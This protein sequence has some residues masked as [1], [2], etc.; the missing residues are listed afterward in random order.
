MG[1][2]VP[3]WKGDPEPFV[4]LGINLSLPVDKLPPGKYRAL[5]NVRPY[6]NGQIIGRV[7]LSPA[8][9]FLLPFAAHS[10]KL[11]NDPV[12]LASRPGNQC[13]E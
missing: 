12:R 7:G 6:G 9:T 3:E 2:D 1:I 11:L 10:M 5:Q 13:S 8:S 4:C